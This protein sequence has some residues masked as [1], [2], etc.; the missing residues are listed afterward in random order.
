MMVPMDGIPPEALLAGYP[1]PMR[2]IAERLRSVA[3][4]PH[5]VQGQH[6]SDRPDAIVGP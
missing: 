6:Q 4:D 2:R 3:A 1:E 5:R